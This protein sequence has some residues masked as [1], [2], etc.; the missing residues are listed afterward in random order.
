LQF[1]HELSGDSRPLSLSVG[2]RLCKILTGRIRAVGA[3]LWFFAKW[4]LSERARWTG[5]VR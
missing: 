1:A 5:V 3:E 2:N 4:Q